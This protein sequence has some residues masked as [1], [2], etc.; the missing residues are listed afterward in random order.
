MAAGAGG[1]E[2]FAEVTAEVTLGTRFASALSVDRVFAGVPGVG[3]TGF[4]S[5][6]GFAPASKVFRVVSGPALAF[7]EGPSATST[8]GATAC[9]GPAAGARSASW[10]DGFVD[11]ISAG[12]SPVLEVAGSGF[13]LSVAPR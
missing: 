5:A 13:R 10:V 12:V 8:D 7:S 6:A 1:F 2:L 9:D 3:V 11:A 4:A